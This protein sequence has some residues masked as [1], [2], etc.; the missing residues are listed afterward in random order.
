MIGLNALVNGLANTIIDAVESGE[1]SAGDLSDLINWAQNMLP[2]I[3]AVSRPHALAVDEIPILL[4]S[5]D[6]SPP[7]GRKVPRKPT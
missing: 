3:V 5:V 6:V 1:Y 7:M 4:Q 2:N